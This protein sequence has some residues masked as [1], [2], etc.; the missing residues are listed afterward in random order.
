MRYI[1]LLFLFF[2]SFN[3][4]ALILGVGTHPDNFKG[5]VDDFFNLLKEYNIKSIRVD[6]T[7]SHIETSKGVFSVDNKKTDQIIS[8][9]K[10][11]GVIPLVVLDYGNPIYKLDKPI[12]PEQVNL[13]TNYV[14]WVVHHFG[15]KVQY[16]EVWNEWS[17]SKPHDVWRSDESAQQYVNLVKSVSNVIKSSNH[18]NIVIAGSFNPTT[19]DDLAWGLNLVKDGILNYV[20]GLSLHPYLYRG[21]RSI[22]DS[23]LDVKYIQKAHNQFLKFSGGREVSFYITEIGIPTSKNVRFSD[24]SIVNFYSSYVN[25]IK[26][27]SYVKGVWWY[28]FINDGNN[29]KDD[30]DNFGMLNYDLSPKSS[31]QLFKLIK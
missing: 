20:D 23:D 11:R 17:M 19:P 14:S 24:S 2:L 4:N 18:N 21:R 1:T 25:K 8:Q 27:L 30:E 5:S 15:T 6:Y 13:F 3:A 16:Y 26:S 29:S 7:W 28:D 10:S 22:S 12:T 31:T 9:A